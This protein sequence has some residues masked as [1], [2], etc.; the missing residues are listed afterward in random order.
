M[1]IRK[2]FPTSRGEFDIRISLI[3]VCKMHADAFFHTA[4][5]DFAN[6]QSEAI[7]FFFY[8]LG[9]HCKAIFTNY[10]D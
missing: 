3:L 6:A 1:Y 5:A 8:F 10:T 4:I 7:I 9:K 2:H